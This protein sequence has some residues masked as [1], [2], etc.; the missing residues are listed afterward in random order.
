MSTALERSIKSMRMFDENPTY[1][2][3]SSFGLDEFIANHLLPVSEVNFPN[4]ALVKLELHG[5]FLFNYI[6]TFTLDFLIEFS[7]ACLVQ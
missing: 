1:I 7:E 2:Y 4:I 6:L 3:E 5:P